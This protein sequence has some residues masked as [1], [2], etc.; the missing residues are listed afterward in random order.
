[1]WGVDFLRKTMGSPKV[2]EARERLDTLGASE[3]PL[4]LLRAQWSGDSQA[5]V[6]ESCWGPAVAGLRPG[7]GG[8]RSET[9]LQRPA[10]RGQPLALT[11]SVL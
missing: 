1:M 10:E 5:G 7:F 2:F 3:R 4:G 9:P 8:S 6:M 11:E